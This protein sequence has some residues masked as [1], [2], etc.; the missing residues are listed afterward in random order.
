[1]EEIMEI[2]LSKALR[3]AQSKCVGLFQHPMSKDVELVVDMDGVGFTTIA[4]GNLF[5]LQTSH[6]GNEYLSYV[7]PFPNN[8][9]LTVMMDEPHAFSEWYN[10]R[11]K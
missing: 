7:I 3:K 1:M 6:F 9:T 5:G 2:Q 4:I 10:Q 11:F 8:K